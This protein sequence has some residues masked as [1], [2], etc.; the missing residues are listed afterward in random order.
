DS[1]NHTL[2]CGNAGH[3]PAYLVRRGQ[4]QEIAPEGMALGLV[5]A[6][7]FFVEERVVELLPGDLIALYTDGV[8]EA[9]NSAHQEYG[10]E[11]F[12]DALASA[13]TK[14]LAQ[15]LQYL[16]DSV[17]AFVGDAPPHDDITLVLLRRKA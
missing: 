16:I 13:Q 1:A 8:T 7:Q 6:A 12:K 11:R 15:A 14:P 4:V 2:I 5:P 17:R 10:E 9:M 3:N